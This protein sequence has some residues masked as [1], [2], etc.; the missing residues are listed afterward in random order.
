LTVF[1]SA[2]GPALFSVGTDLFGTYHA[3]EWL[4]LVGLILLTLAAMVVRQDDPLLTR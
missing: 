1:A 4:C 2:I 3:A